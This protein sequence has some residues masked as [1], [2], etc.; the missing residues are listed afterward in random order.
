MT[1]FCEP[2][3]FGR[4]ASALSKSGKVSPPTP[5]APICRKLRRGNPSQQ[6]NRFPGRVSMGRPQLSDQAGSCGWGRSGASANQQELLVFGSPDS[7]NQVCRGSCTRSSHLRKSTSAGRC[8]IL[9]RC[10]RLV[11]VRRVEIFPRNLARIII[12]RFHG[13]STEKHIREQA[14]CSLHI[15]GN[16]NIQKLASTCADAFHNKRGSGRGA[17]PP[18]RSHL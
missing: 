11:N 13:S 4:F 2:D 14:V 17:A 8:N 16:C 5:S 10:Q 12:E 15:P 9:Q 7:P 3:R 18:V 6:R 1:D